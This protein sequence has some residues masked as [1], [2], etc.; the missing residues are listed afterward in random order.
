MRALA[1]GRVYSGRQALANGLTDAIGGEAEARQWLSEEM[2]VG[3]DLPIVDVTIGDETEAWLPGLCSLSENMALSER[4][5]L[6]GLVAVWH[7][8]VS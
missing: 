5:T 7:P 6:D 8:D 1:D 3:A 4:L 2:G